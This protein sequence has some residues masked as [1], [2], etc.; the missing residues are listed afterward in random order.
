MKKT[1]VS[2]N[3]SSKVTHIRL[4][5]TYSTGPNDDGK[6]KVVQGLG[7]LE[8]NEKDWADKRARFHGG[9]HNVCA[10]VVALKSLAALGTTSMAALAANEPAEAAEHVLE[11]GSDD[12]LSTR[13]ELPQHRI[14]NIPAM[15]GRRSKTYRHPFLRFVEPA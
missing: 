11:Y 7:Q 8:Q 3:M 13:D 2:S 15:A 9:S 5:G 12:G 14:I 4:G 10:P 1:K 6:R